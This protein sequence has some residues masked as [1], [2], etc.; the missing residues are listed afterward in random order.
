MPTAQAHPASEAIMRP[1]NMTTVFNLRSS[2]TITGIRYA[3]AQSASF[4]PMDGYPWQGSDVDWTPPFGLLAMF[5]S[6][7]SLRHVDR[8]TRP[9]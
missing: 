3:L 1:N 7:T 9:S 5:R 4:A 6:E 2:G 8:Q